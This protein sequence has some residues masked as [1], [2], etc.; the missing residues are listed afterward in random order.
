MTSRNTVNISILWRRRISEWVNAINQMLVRI[1]PRKLRGSS[2][3][4]P[5]QQIVGNAKYHACACS[6]L[7]EFISDRGSCA[8]GICIEAIRFYVIVVSNRDKSSSFTFPGTYA[9]K[10]Q[11]GNMGCVGVKGSISRGVPPCMHVA[12]I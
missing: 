2:C 5:M 3:L 7:V 6:V 9:H 4:P 11:H 12:R 10:L 1:N 8:A